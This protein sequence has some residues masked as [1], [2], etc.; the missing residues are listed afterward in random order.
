MLDLLEIR[1]PDDLTKLRGG[2][3]EFGCEVAAE[4]NLCD[5]VSALASATNN[6]AS[7]ACHCERVSLRGTAQF[8]RAERYGGA[9]SMAAERGLRTLD[10]TS[11]PS[12]ESALRLYE[13]VGF[14]RRETNIL[15]YTPSEP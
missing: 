5:K 2:L 4:M 1:A 6:L 3:S 14:R 10:L 15:R 12:R 8:D 7:V 11:R 13:G 9:G